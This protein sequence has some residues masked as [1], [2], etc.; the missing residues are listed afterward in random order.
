MKDITGQELHYGDLVVYVRDTLSSIDRNNHYGI[1]ISDSE[2]WTDF[3]KLNVKQC[4]LCYLARGTEGEKGIKKDLIKNY[5]AYMS[6]LATRLFHGACLKSAGDY[7]VYKSA[8]SCLPRGIKFLSG[9]ASKN[10]QYLVY[11][12][13]VKSMWSGIKDMDAYELNDLSNI[14]TTDSYAYLWYNIDNSAVDE[15]CNRF[16]NL[17]SIDISEEKRYMNNL[18]I[19]LD[20]GELC[21]KYGKCEFFVQTEPILELDQ[22]LG[23]CELKSWDIGSVLTLLGDDFE[24]SDTV[25]FTRVE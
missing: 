4:S 18:C 24:F 23:R 17:T 8:D 15:F 19:D 14:Y 11:L 12:G 10:T 7:G 6:Q 5:N 13:K 21:R 2:L 1:V 9:H 3:G 25:S 16:P 22:Y 20:S